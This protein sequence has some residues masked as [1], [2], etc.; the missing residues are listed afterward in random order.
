MIG[1]TV[2]FMDGTTEEFDWAEGTHGSVP[3]C[4]GGALSMETWETASSTYLSGIVYA[5]GQ[6]KSVKIRTGLRKVEI[7]NPNGGQAH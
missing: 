1:A 7:L 5:P 2:T 6:W 3:V 4:N